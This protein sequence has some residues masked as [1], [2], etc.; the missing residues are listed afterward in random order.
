MAYTLIIALVGGFCA[1]I[2]IGVL[3]MISIFLQE[4]KAKIKEKSPESRAIKE[5]TH[6]TKLVNSKDPDDILQMLYVKLC[7][8]D[9]ESNRCA[10]YADEHLK[11]KS[12]YIAVNTRGMTNEK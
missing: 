11:D 4:K 3:R 10:S 8:D 12:D 5:I 7:M 1:N 9:D 6:H 2:V